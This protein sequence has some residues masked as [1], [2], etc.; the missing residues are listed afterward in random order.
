MLDENGDF[1]YTKIE[2]LIRT[3]E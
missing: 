1:L 3:C 2:A